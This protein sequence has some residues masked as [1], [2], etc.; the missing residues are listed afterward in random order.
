[1]IKNETTYQRAIDRLAGSSE[2]TEGTHQRILQA[3][4]QTCP[5]L[6]SGTTGVAREL[7]ARQIHAHSG[8]ADRPFVPFRGGRL[9]ARIADQ[10]LFGHARGEF[11]IAR[12]AALGALGAAQGGTL[13]VD[14]VAEL[15]TSA[16]DRLVRLL[17]TKQAVS[18]QPDGSRSDADC[19]VRLIAYSAR[20][21]T[22][23]AAEGRFSVDLLQLLSRI[24]VEA[25]PL[26][27]RIDHLLN[28]ARKAIA[29]AEA[30]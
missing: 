5:V 19:D 7:I 14:E 16:Q 20:D 25:M 22:R 15:S 29:S 23:L 28:L 18:T 13:Y 17:Q 9:P 12:G 30:S 10:Q 6:I 11:S 2:W 3:A 8:R 21:L 27:Q 24:R 26:E 1:M 4:T